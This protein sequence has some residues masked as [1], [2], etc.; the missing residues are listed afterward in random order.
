VLVIGPSGAGKSTFARALGRQSGLPV[1][2]LDRIYWLPGWQKAPQ[3]ASRA[4]LL[5][6]AAETRWI[7]EGAYPDALDVCLARA[8]KVFVF[9]CHRVGCLWRVMVRVSAN[10]GRSQPDMP[11]GS[12][13]RFNWDFMREIWQK[14]GLWHAEIM[15]TI[16]RA[17][18]EDRLTV[19]RS[20]READQYLTRSP[21][22]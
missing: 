8:Q 18:A 13:E 6:A 3:E 12:P 16:S 5:Q 14:S 21:R 7:I 10:L 17:R 9:R 19:F 2:H 20:P 22:A 4:A 15:A 11:E 1:V